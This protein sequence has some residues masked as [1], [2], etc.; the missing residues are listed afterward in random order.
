MKKYI[1]LLR[2]HSTKGFALADQAVVSGGNFLTSILYTRLLGLESYGT[3]IL[4]WMIVLFISGLQQAFIL[5]PMT[6]IYAYKTIQDKIKLYLHTLL[7][8]QII[9]S[10]ACSIFVLLALQLNKLF[11]QSTYFKDLT[12]ILPA[13]IFAFIMHDFFRRYFMLMGKSFITLLLDVLST[14]LLLFLLYTN[15]IV[16]IKDVFKIIAFS[17]VIPAT[18]GYFSSGMKIGFPLIKYSVKAHWIQGKWLMAT[19]VLQLFSG[20]YFIIL[21]AGILGTA[22]IG[23]IRI[24]QNIVGILNVLFIAMES[25]I[26][27]SASKIFHNLGMEALIHYLKRMALQ[28]VI[29]TSFI[30]ILLALFTQDLIKIL[31][32]NDFIQYTP[33]VQIYALF[34]I[35]VFI[36]LPLRF[37]IKTI[38]Q[39]HH[40]LI[41]YAISTLFS[42]LT[43]RFFIVEFGI[44][45]VLSGIIIT[46]LLT[47]LYYIYALKKYNHAHHSLSVR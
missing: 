15:I 38:E 27:I 43:A 28:G 36:S 22:E 11:I 34:Y 47:Q 25:Y 42:L 2:M 40:I 45:G 1:P 18:I 23:I 17:Y 37:A 39:N 24:A 9:F 10:L 30:C 14:L 5:S 35:L 44:Y 8:M 32:S 31:Y 21:A 4:C 29:I 19:S 12:F 26:P 46:Q 7:S 41:G 6:T 16:E 20:N 33:I 3:F 13:S